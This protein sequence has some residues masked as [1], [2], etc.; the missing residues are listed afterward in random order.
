MGFFFLFYTSVQHVNSSLSISHVGKNI[1]SSCEMCKHPWGHRGSPMEKVCLFSLS[2]R[3]CS[4]SKAPIG[5]KKDLRE[6]V[7][8][9][10][11]QNKQMLRL[12]I[13]VWTRCSNIESTDLLLISPE[14]K[15]EVNDEFHEPPLDNCTIPKSSWDYVRSQCNSFTAQL[16]Q[17]LLTYL[18]DAI[19]SC[20]RKRK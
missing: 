9:Y 12:L 19:I 14:V 10:Q 13:S 17:Q 18:S 4:N 8:T 1:H 7:S 20:Y 15:E 5:L 2:T 16:S 3:H 11:N 6:V